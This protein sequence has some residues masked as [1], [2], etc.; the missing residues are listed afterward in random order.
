MEEV[1]AQMQS[2]DITSPTG[3]A[4]RRRAEMKQ[5]NPRAYEQATKKAKMRDIRGKYFNIHKFQRKT[6]WVALEL[7]E[8]LSRGESVTEELATK[9]EELCMEFQKSHLHVEETAEQC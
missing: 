5:T 3:V 8:K 6:K 1:A 7:Q 2:V 9:R 4:E